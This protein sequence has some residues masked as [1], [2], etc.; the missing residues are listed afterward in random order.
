MS[1][2]Y[3]TKDYGSVD[4][5]NKKLKGKT[6]LEKSYRGIK[7]DDIRNLSECLKTNN[8]LKI[9]DLRHNHVGTIGVQSLV[10]SLKDN[11]TL[12][13]LDIR[14]NR[15][16]DQGAKH[17]SDLLKMNGVLTSLNLKGNRIGDGGAYY[18]SEALKTNTTL[19][20]LNLRANWLTLNGAKLIYE[21]LKQNH[22]LTELNVGNT[23]FESVWLRERLLKK[24][25]ENKFGNEK[26]RML[27][28]CCYTLQEDSV[29]Y[30]ENLPLD[31][32]KIIWKLSGVSKK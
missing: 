7:K 29:F 2:K 25:G 23:F 26:K 19:T 8:A 4:Y 30:K 31:V 21:G 15:I 11:K 14:S 12:T 18:I 16:R 9:L 24:L 27:L 32:F 20:S 22:T 28:L 3:N 6:K 13:E 17:L 5:W 10:E 1:N